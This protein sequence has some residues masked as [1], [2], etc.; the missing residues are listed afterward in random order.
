MGKRSRT[1]I[2]TGSK[3]SK[4]RRI[5]KTEI[6]LCF[7]CSE[8]LEIGQLIHSAGSGSSKWYHAE[9]FEKTRQ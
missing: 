1:Y 6:I 3:Q 4:I 5:L 2:L 7:K 9:C 8:P